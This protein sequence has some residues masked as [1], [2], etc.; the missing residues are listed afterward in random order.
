MPEQ[1]SIR[2]LCE[3]LVD[4]YHVDRRKYPWFSHRIASALW[5]L[6][7]PSGWSGDRHGIRPRNPF[8][9]CTA[10]NAGSENAQHGISRR[11]PFSV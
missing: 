2:R 4:V 10:G 3:T 9:I 8:G 1:E 7:R 11:S 6:Y 5:E